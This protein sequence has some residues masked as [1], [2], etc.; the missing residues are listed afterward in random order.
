MVACRVATVLYYFQLHQT[1]VFEL[2]K[3]NFHLP[4]KFSKGPLKRSRD[5]VTFSGFTMSVM[6]RHLEKSTATQ[7]YARLK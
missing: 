3:T 7:S 1:V 5:V 6:N 2:L 4:L